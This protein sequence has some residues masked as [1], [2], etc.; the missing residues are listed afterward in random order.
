MVHSWLKEAELA[1][2]GRRSLCKKE[3]GLQAKDGGGTW[4]PFSCTLSTLGLCQ[5]SDRE[6]VG[7]LAWWCYV[8]KT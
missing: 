8:N 1:A 5:P 7:S 2:L 4:W 3:I 6:A